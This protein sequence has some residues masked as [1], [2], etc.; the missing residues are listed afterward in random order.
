MH[1][2]ASIHQPLIANGVTDPLGNGSRSIRSQN[3]RSG[4]QGR[5]IFKFHRRHDCHARFCGAVNQP[6]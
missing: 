4:R 2:E 6:L 1:P 3:R 5:F